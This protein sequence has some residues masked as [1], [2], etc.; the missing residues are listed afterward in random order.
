MSATAGSIEVRQM[1]ATDLQRGFL[2]CLAAFSALQMTEDEA[3]AVFQHRLRA[4]ISTFV[5]LENDRVIGTASLFI[6]PK[7]LH[8]GGL[9]GHIE[10]V[11]VH[12]DL[13]GRGIGGMIVRHLIEISRRH[14]CYKVILD[15]ADSLIPYYE[16][17]GF[18]PWASGM[19][20]D[21]PVEKSAGP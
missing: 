4:R 5:A 15:C 8:N 13:Q 14:G 19:R 6:E 7:F 18:R 12:P 10:D 11:A 21:L 2:D 1:F 9:V 3:I 17:L 20:M 16:K